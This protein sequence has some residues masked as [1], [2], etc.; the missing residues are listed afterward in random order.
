[1]LFSKGFCKIIVEAN[2]ASITLAGQLFLYN[3]KTNKF[4]ILKKHGRLNAYQKRWILILI[5][6]ASICLRILD[7]KLLAKKDYNCNS[8]AKYKLALMM[9]VLVFVVAEH[10]RVRG[11]FAKDYLSFLNAAAFIE[12]KYDKG[13]LLKHYNYK[14]KVATILT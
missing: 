2:Q 10:F 13:N 11:F 1:M 14:H 6:L 5:V 8:S 4:D 3:E 9:L 7:Y 12:R